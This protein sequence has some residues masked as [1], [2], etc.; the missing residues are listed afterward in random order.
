[1]MFSKPSHTGFYLAL[2]AILAVIVFSV[3]DAGATGNTQGWC[4]DRWGIPYWCGLQ[5]DRW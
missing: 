1:M 2:G 4:I 5:G 3:S